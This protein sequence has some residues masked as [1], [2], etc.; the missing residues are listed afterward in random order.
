MNLGLREGPLVAASKAEVLG[1]VNIPPSP[2]NSV[3]YV[4]SV[5]NSRC[6]PF[7]LL[8]SR[9][10]MRKSKTCIY[11]RSVK[12]FLA[13]RAMLGCKIMPAPLHW[14]ALVF[15][16]VAMFLDHMVVSYFALLFECAYLPIW[17][18]AISVAFQVR[19]LL[20]CEVPVSISDCHGLSSQRR[21][22]PGSR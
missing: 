11:S 20:V 22:P 10:R 18:G 3:S 8:S 9:K 16:L 2:Q 6:S 5:V 15:P 4:P 21:F 17:N 13:Y 12:F 19:L 14:E 1:T 7:S